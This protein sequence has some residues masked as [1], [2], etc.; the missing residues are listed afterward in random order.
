MLQAFTCCKIPIIITILQII[1]LWITF[2]ITSTIPGMSF[3]RGLFAF[4]LAVPLDSGMISS[5]T[6][7]GMWAFLPSVG[8]A[9]TSHIF[10]M[11]I[12]QLHKNSHEH[13]IIN[14]SCRIQNTNAANKYFLGFTALEIV[15]QQKTKGS[16]KGLRCGVAMEIPCQ[17]I[18][19]SV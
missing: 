2:T 14:F 11:Q 12:D 4:C 10:K 3:E 8:A 17:T 15:G 19:Q 5:L 9:R 7:R 13:R 1:D 18:C 6:E 16:Y